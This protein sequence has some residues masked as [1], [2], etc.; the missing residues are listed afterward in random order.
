MALDSRSGVYAGLLDFLASSGSGQSWRACSSE[1]QGLT[2][3]EINGLDYGTPWVA[4]DLFYCKLRSP[5]AIYLL[6]L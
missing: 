5:A 4:D 6:A 1:R 3:E 2:D